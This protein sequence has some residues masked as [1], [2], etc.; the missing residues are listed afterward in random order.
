MFNTRCVRLKYEAKWKLSS[1][2]PDSLA[3][4]QCRI[5]S[6]FL[7]YQAILTIGKGMNLLSFSKMNVQVITMFVNI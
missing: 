4:P 5:D 1:S 2:V 7:A 6:K 3:R